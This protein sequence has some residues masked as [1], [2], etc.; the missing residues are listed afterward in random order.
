MHNR[1]PREVWGL[2]DW[3][4]A[5]AY[6]AKWKTREWQWEF[7]RRRQDYREL[8]RKWE[9]TANGGI[10]AVPEEEIDRGMFGVG[11]LLDPRR[12]F[13]DWEL[14]SLMR[15]RYGFQVVYDPH[16]RDGDVFDYRFDLTKPGA[17]QF[18][19]AR[20]HFDAVQ[21]ERLGSSKVERPSPEL[22]PTYL[23]TLDARDC[24]ASWSEIGGT[25]WPNDNGDVAAKARTTHARAL[26]TRP[27]R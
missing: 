16:R 27:E 23:R 26:V 5:T 22:W 15:P 14:M 6:P 19:A 3:R 25:L 4:D 10:A 1:T 13:T 11:R 2:P 21:R 7:T 8:W 12:S 20:K 9:H 18:A 17:P 24:G